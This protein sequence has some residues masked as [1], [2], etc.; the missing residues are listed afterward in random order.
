ML[1]EV[2]R[3]SV[4]NRQLPTRLEY[5][6]FTCWIL[7]YNRQIDMV[8][9]STILISSYFKTLIWPPNCFHSNFYDFR[10]WVRNDSAYGFLCEKTDGHYYCLLL[11]IIGVLYYTS[12]GS[13]T[14][15]IFLMQLTQAFRL[16][17][18][19]RII[20]AADLKEIVYPLLLFYGA[21]MCYIPTYFKINFCSIYFYFTEL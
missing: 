12:S 4:F 9:L 21:L 19:A 18:Y 16:L 13:N 3:I 5:V 7:F 11:F 15:W 14:I 10:L 8:I 17:F 2:A 1:P 20:I 6:G